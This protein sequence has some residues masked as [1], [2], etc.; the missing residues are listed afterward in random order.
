[1]EVIAAPSRVEAYLK[2][3]GI[4][5]HFS[6]R[7]AFA[8]RH[9]SPGELLASPFARTRFLQFIVEGRV[10]LYDM[11]DEDTVAG[12]E[13]PAYRATLIG[14]AELFNP[15]FPTFFVEAKTEVYTLALSLDEYRDRLLEDNAFLRFCCFT[16]TEKLSHATSAEQKLPVREQLLKFIEKAVPDEPI[17][18]LTHLALLL[19][20][21]TRHLARVFRELCEEGVLERKKKGVYRIRRQPAP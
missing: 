21:S 13:T 14:D 5:E 18:N 4:Q 3:Y 17:R 10:M 7:P 15:G 16:F 9:Y 8:L 11:P 1:M 6:C 19:H 2:K 12:I 20:T